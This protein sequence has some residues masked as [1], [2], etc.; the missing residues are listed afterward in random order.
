MTSC[1]IHRLLGI[2]VLGLALACGA[3]AADTETTPVQNVQIDDFATGKKAIEAKNWKA[4][5]DSF[6]K[7]VA[8][9]S[10]NAD[11]YNLLGFSLR[12]QNRYDDAFAAYGKALALDPNHKGALH[13]SGI[14]YLKSGKKEQAE[15]QLARLKAVCAACD[16]TVQLGKAVAE[17]Q[18]AA[19]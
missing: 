4:A 13:Y 12:W 17:A 2:P 16:E 18:V 8:K 9:D 5:S 10:R 14:A 6:A 7:V 3:Y 15:A 1:T 19:K 11:A